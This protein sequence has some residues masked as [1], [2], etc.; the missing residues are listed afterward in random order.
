MIKSKNIRELTKKEK[1]KGITILPWKIIF[2]VC[3]G[4]LPLIPLFVVPIGLTLYVTFYILEDFDDDIMEIIR[5]N[6]SSKLRKKNE[7]YS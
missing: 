1:I 5:I 7:F 4:G 2:M 6:L 3:S